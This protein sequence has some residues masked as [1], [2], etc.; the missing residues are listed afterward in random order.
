MFTACLHHDVGPA[1]NT[2][3]SSGVSFPVPLAASKELIYRYVPAYFST[4]VMF[5]LVTKL[6]PELTVVPV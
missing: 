4:G 3:A 2:E 6:G 1:G 5:A